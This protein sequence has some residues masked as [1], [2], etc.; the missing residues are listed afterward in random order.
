MDPRPLAFA[1]GVIRRRESGAVTVLETFARP[2]VS[3]LLYLCANEG[4]EILA[5]DGGTLG[6]RPARPTPVHGKRRAERILAAHEIIRWNVGWRLG[7]KL[8]LAYV[9]EAETA[10]LDT[11]TGS[12]RRPRGH[13]R[14]AHWH[15]FWTGRRDPARADERR[16]V[17]RWI[18]PVPV[19]VDPDGEDELPAVIRP[20]E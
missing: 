1:G 8:R 16:L 14:R 10:G 9:G 17:L 5:A 11:S 19:N 12:R 7:A 18:P 4:A 20:V 13:I 3:M 2:F 6:R 15:H